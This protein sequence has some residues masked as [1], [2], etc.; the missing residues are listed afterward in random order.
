MAEARVGPIP[1]TWER[2]WGAP[3]LTSTPMLLTQNSIIWSA[4]FFK[5]AGARSF[6]YMPTPTDEDS[7]LVNSLRG[8]CSRRAMDTALRHSGATSGSSETASLETEYTDDPASSTTAYLRP[9][10]SDAI[11]STVFRL[12]VPFPIATNSTRNSSTIAKADLVAASAP[13]LL[14]WGCTTAT[15]RTLPVGSTTAILHP[16]LYPGST[17]RMHLR[18]TGACMRTAWKLFE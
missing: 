7:I 6:W 12:A 14:P 1:A 8:S 4:R 9:L 2:R 13:S 11:H 16:W 10:P 18:V 3:V 5:T 15:R 17:P